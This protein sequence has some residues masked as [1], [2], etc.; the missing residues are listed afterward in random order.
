MISHLYCTSNVL[1]IYLIN[2]SLLYAQ[3]KFMEYFD[4][5][6]IGGIHGVGTV[7]VIYVLSKNLKHKT[8]LCQCV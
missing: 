4:N 3:V 2:S 6:D 5:H 7:S 1:R 8:E